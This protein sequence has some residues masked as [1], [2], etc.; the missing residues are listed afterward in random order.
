MKVALIIP[1]HNRIDYLKKCLASIEVSDIPRD[2][3]LL[4]IN[5]ASTN[6]ETLD[7]SYYPNIDK[8]NREE[9]IFKE[10]KGIKGVLKYGFERCFS[11]G[12]DIVISLD[13]DTIVVPNFFKKIIALRSMFIDNIV[14]GINSTNY[15]NGKLRNPIVSEYDNFIMKKFT[16][17]QCLCLNE[18][19]YNRFVKGALSMNGNWDYNASLATQKENISVLVPKPSLVQHIGVVSSMSHIKYGEPDVA[20]DFPKIKLTNVTLFGVDAHDPNGI[21]RASEISQRHIEFGAVKIITERIF[22]GRDGYSQFCIKEMWKYIETDYVL[23]IHSDGFIQNAWAWDDSWLQYDLIGASWGYKDNM[24]V[25]NGGFTLRSKKLLNIIKDYDVPQGTIEDDFICRKIRRELEIKHGIKFAP[26]EVANKFSIEAYGASA[27][28]DMQGFK[29]NTY[30]G[31]MGFHGY[32]VQ[33]LPIP[34]LPKVPTPKVR[35]PNQITRKSI[36]KRT[37]RR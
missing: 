29:A 25:G 8:I 23:L 20:L 35:K 22:D 28:T 16:N 10:N 12:Y 37:F 18:S 21:L 27:F 32:Q 1:Y 24:N 7:F 6:F 19:S 26:E 33:G 30:S 2:L 15:D 14:C 17:G 11:M 3:F 4:V 34:P 31:Q 5:D 13:S 9:F 36:A